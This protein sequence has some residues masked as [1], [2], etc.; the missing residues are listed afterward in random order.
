MVETREQQNRRECE[1]LSYVISDVL[2]HGDDSDTFKA[3]I[4]H[5]CACVLDLV[6]YLGAGLEALDYRVTDK[7]IMLIMMM[8]LNLFSSRRRR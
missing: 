1:E 3:L 8:R 7:I 5:K 4:Y 2:N 6:S